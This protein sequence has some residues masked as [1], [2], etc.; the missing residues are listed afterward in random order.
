MKTKTKIRLG[1]SG[2][3]YTIPMHYSNLPSAIT[4]KNK[5]YSM[6]GWSLTRNHHEDY[7]V[8]KQIKQAVELSALDPLRG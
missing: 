7:I 1:D 3:F 6:R 4:H 8:Y 2:D 5:L